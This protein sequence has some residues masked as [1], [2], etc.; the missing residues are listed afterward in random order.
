LHFRNHVL[1]DMLQKCRRTSARGFEK[2][3]AL[4][5]L[6]MKPWLRDACTASSA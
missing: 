6:D 2:R 4:S 3:E 1:D 5:L